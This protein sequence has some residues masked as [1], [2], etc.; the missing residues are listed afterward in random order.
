MGKR[1]KN[2]HVYDRHTSLSTTIQSSGN[3]KCT[4][5]GNINTGE[6]TITDKDGRSLPVENSYIERTRGR[7]KSAIKGDKV[8]FSAMVDKL[9]LNISDHLNDFDAVYAVDTNTKDQNG[10]FYSYGVCLKVDEFDGH[11]AR[12]HIFRTIT[13]ENSFR[14]GQMEQAVWNC[15]IQEILREEPAHSQIGLIVDCDLGNIPLYNQRK[16]KIRDAEYLPE[17]FT[18]I[19]ASA[20]DA[21]SIF[22]ALIN[23]CEKMSKAAIEDCFS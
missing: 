6:F 22:N 11:S 12:C 4:I 20:D 3:M 15:I 9:S 7:A 2:K 14:K 23:K 10:V 5:Q 21:D 19:Y 13:S 8:L 1:K 18:L 16:L 17:N